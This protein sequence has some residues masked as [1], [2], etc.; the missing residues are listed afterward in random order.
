MQV[1]QEKACTFLD[2]GKVHK[3]TPSGYAIVTNV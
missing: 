3:T 2:L 1:I